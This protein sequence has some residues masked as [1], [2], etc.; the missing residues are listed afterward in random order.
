MDKVNTDFQA[1][2]SPIP[3]V[4]ETVTSPP[5]T[6]PLS[7]NADLSSIQGAGFKAVFQ[8][9]NKEVSPPP[10]PPPLPEISASPVTP[11]ATVPTNPVTDQ[12]TLIPPKP[13]KKGVGGVKN[14][15]LGSFLVLVLT[16]LVLGFGKARSFLSSA[17]GGCTPDN[18]TET[19]LTANSIEIVF[20]TGKACQ[21]EV[22]YGTSSEAML[23]QVPEAMASL[24]HR[25]RLAPLLAS[26]TYYYQIIANGKKVSA[27]RS[28]L[29]KAA[30]VSVS[31][32]PVLVPTENPVV[33][34]VPESIA[35]S[36][37]ASSA[38]ASRYTLSD[39]EPY[40]G[41]S[42]AVFDID[43]NGIVNMRD[44]LLYQEQ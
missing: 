19:N 42:S 18:I 8:N 20:Q 3:L 9:Q 27:P 23:L 28:F 24:N 26:T 38:A 1:T 31:P 14:V 40:F 11:T 29:T 33:S 36:V 43:K 2:P 5:G 35:P 17:E 10:P 13:Q 21:M 22:A 32:T 25:I 6:P 39:F 34:P 41:T 7:G 44:W 15:L 4:T 16:G 37:A 30:E 12:S